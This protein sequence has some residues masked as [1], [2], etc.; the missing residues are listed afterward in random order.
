MARGALKIP[1]SSQLIDNTQRTVMTPANRRTT[2]A[3]VVLV[4]A[5]AGCSK[6]PCEPTRATLESQRLGVIL[7]GGRV[8]S[9]QDRVL[10]IDYPNIDD[11]II[12]RDRYRV[13]LP[14]RGWTVEV[15]DSEN[16]LVATRE[17]MSVIIVAV[18]NRERGVPT[19]I[20]R[21]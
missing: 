15:G 16:V 1:I 8:C 19:A 14:S 5:C 12:M 17:E 3:L 7:D 11:F 10:T 9:D 13:V 18:E 2:A 4:L 21:Y 6:R 20:V